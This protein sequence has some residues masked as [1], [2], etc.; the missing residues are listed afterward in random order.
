M[1]ISRVVCYLEC[2]RRHPLSAYFLL[3][4]FRQRER[5]ASDPSSDPRDRGIKA[6][7]LPSGVGF[8]RTSEDRLIHVKAADP[9]GRLP[10]VV[11]VGG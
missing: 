6:S 10:S 7:I 11:G 2:R 3:Q 1:Y 8:Y 5:V 4:S 9:F